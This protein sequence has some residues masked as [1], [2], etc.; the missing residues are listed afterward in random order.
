MGE[1]RLLQRR[2]PMSK[3]GR[4]ADAP[5]P[6]PVRE[7]MSLAIEV[8]QAVLARTGPGDEALAEAIRWLARGASES[9]GGR[10][11]ALWAVLYARAAGNPERAVELH[12]RVRRSLEA[13]TAHQAWDRDHR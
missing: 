11:R 10:R 7:D 5:P 6:L 1:A 4:E 12:E 13:F 8:V 2:P 3:S 9:D